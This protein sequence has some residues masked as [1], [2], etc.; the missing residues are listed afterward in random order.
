MVR[1]EDRSAGDGDVFKPFGPRP[2]KRIDNREEGGAGYPVQQWRALTHQ[3]SRPG[4]LSLLGP[5]LRRLPRPSGS[6]LKSCDELGEF[7]D[8]QPAGVGL[9]AWFARM[10]GRSRA[11]DEQPHDPTHQRKK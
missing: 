11:T 2:V 10:R 9:K 3:H 5:G 6:A 8:V 4:S 7:L 1:G